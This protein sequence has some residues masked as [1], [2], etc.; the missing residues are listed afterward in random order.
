MALNRKVFFSLIRDSAFGG[1]LSQTQV[2]GMTQVLDYWEARYLE[3]VRPK[4]LAYMLATFK[5][6]TA[7]TMQPVSEGM[8]A[9]SGNRLLA[10]QKKL[11]YYPYHGRGLVQITHA[12]NYR[13]FGIEDRPDDAMKWPKALEIAFEGM[14][15]GVF[16]GKKL[17]DY[18]SGDEFDPRGARAIIQGKKR[19]TD[20]Y[21]AQF[22]EVA[23][24]YYQF[25]AAIKAAIESPNITAVAKP[26]KP[27]PE[28]PDAPIQTVP[29]PISPAESPTTGP[30]AVQSNTVWSQ[31][32]VIVTTVVTPVTAAFA[33]I[34][35]RVAAVIGTVVVVGFSVWT[36]SDGMRK[37]RERGV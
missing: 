6:E 23:A 28:R 18:M 3:K 35:W 11:Y 10:Y 12:A 21:S 36:I 20:Q 7:H 29:P 33:G 32:G 27:D 8:P 26:A 14:T 37:S 30:A 19:K 31:I 25:Y 15:R 16:T 34:D 5:H 1:T 17:R 13:R 4:E 24:L 22:A 9:L 2:D